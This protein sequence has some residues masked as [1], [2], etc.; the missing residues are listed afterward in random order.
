MYFVHYAVEP[1]RLSLNLY[2]GEYST[3]LKVNGRLTTPDGRLVHQFD[4]TVAL[5]L[6][7]EQVREASRSP[8]DFQDLFPAPR[9]RLR[10]VG[11]HQERGLE[12]IHVRR[13]RP[14]HPAARRR[15]RADPAAARLPGRPAGARG[16]ADEGLPRRS[17]TRSTASPA[18]SSPGR[19]RWRSSSSSTIWSPELAASGEVRIAFLKDGQPFREIRRKPSEYPDL[20]VVLEEVALADFPPAHYTVRVSVAK[21]RDRDR[22]VRRGVR[23]E[24]RRGRA[25][26]L[27]LVAHPAERRGPLLRGDLRAP[28]SSTSA[29]TTR[30]ACSW[31]RRFQ[32]KPDSEET[33]GSLARVHL[34]LDDAPAAAKLLV[35]FV[36]PART[37]KYETYVLAAEALQRVGGFGRAVELLDKAVTHYGIN[38]SLMNLTGECYL[39]LG[40][41]PEALAAFEKSLELSPDQPD[42]RKEGRGAEEES[43]PLGLAGLR[44]E[45]RAAPPPGRR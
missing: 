2:E 30:P 35:P 11:P 37:A 44:P 8:F 4:K 20:P 5:K 28:S 12:G 31:R 16:P 45:R 29:A 6:T 17:R 23:P 18:A 38:A 36:D 22:L 27:V 21:R 43:R 39:G 34:A 14:A 42:V 9:R 41:T 24:L 7:E 33:A 32:R 1:R 10:A 3:T 13:E 25:A 19:R 40:K 15:R 26:A